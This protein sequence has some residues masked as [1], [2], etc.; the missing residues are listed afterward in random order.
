[1]LDNLV[2]FQKVRTLEVENERLNVRINESEIVEKKERNDLVA[3]YE[4]KIKE[5]R[6]LIDDALKEKTRT[7]ME[8]KA[9]I[10]ERDNM[11]AKVA[12]K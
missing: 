12:T 2:P 7:N 4:T 1:M 9:A 5:L 11:R 6:D 3:R 10:A 8:A